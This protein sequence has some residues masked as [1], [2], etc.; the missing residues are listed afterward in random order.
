MTVAPSGLSNVQKE[1]LKLYANDVSEQ[2]LF[3]I[4]QILTKH[5][6]EKATKAMDEIWTERGLTAEDMI[7]WTNEHDR[8]ANRS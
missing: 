2:N 4:K 6:A 7:K 8:A 3:E 5:F 1:L